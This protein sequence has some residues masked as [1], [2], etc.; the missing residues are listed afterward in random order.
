MD[1]QGYRKLLAWQKADE[2]AYQVYLAVKKFPPDELYGLTSQIRRAVFSIPANIAEG[3]GRQGRK[4]MKQFLNVSLGSLAE[5]EYS[6]SFCLRLG[7][8]DLATYERLEG[9]RCETGRL[10]WGLFRRF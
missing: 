3:F 1:Q 4:E 2:L 10:L 9:L 7:Y 8:F 5:V 6:L